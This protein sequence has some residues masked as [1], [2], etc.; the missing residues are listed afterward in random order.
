MSRIQ[1]QCTK[2]NEIVHFKIDTIYED[3]K[4]AKHLKGTLE[5]LVWNREENHFYFL[6]N[7]SKEIG[8]MDLRFG[9]IEYYQ[10][11]QEPGYTISKIYC[12]KE[13]LI[14][15]SD[16]TNKIIIQSFNTTQKKFVKRGDLII[17]DA[18]F[19]YILNERLYTLKTYPGDEI[20]RSDSTI[21]LTEV[22]LN[23]LKI[24]NSTAYSSLLPEMYYFYD[25]TPF[26]FYHDKLYWIEN[27]APLLNVVYLKDRTHQQFQITSLACDSIYFSDSVMKIIKNKRVLHYPANSIQALYDAITPKIIF[28]NSLF[29]TDSSLY[30]CISQDYFKGFPNSFVELKWSSQEHGYFIS[31]S[32]PFNYWARQSVKLTQEYIVPQYGIVSFDSKGL[33]SIDVVRKKDKTSQLDNIKLGKYRNENAKIKSPKIWIIK[34]SAF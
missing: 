12:N 23:N 15:A 22:N 11:Y 9:K 17:K 31:K 32:Q 3:L 34:S 26:R 20:Y 33:L 24:E 16:E 4:I 5:D 29:I 10:Y 14:L 18:W 19:F 30:L 8:V 21:I 7:H 25:V 2:E 13:W 28:Y 27:N 1:A 6:H